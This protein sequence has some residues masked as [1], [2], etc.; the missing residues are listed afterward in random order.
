MKNIA[1]WSI[2]RPL[3]PWLIILTCLVGGLYGIDTVGRLE[4]PVFPIKNAYVITVYPGASALEVEQE[5]TDLVEA[6]LQELPYLYKM[7]SKSVPGRSE[8]QVEV[9]EHFKASE[10]PQ[11]WDELRRRVSEAAQRLPPG[12]LTPLVEDDFGDVYGILR[13][14]GTRILPGGYPRHGPGNLQSA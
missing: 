4:D 3:Y 14:L 13:H 12:A 5:V 10:V 6:S 8:I 1:Q 2:E 11:I 9:H 7:T